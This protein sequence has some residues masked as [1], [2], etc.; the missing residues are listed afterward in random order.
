MKI[1]KLGIVNSFLLVIV[2]VGLV[3]AA[4]VSTV[5][6]AEFNWKV[7]ST[8]TRGDPS[9]EALAYFAE[10]VLKRSNGRIKLEIFAEP[11]LLPL[12]EVLP[13]ASRGAIDI[14]HGGGAIWSMV[15]PSGDVIFGSVPGIWTFPGVS[16]KEGH[17]R[18]RKYL[19]ESGAVD[20]IRKEYAKHNLYW[21]DMHGIGSACQLSTKEVHSLKDIKGMKL[22]DLGGWMAQW[23]SA[24]GWIPVEMMGGAEMM[25]ALKLGTIDAVEYDLSAITSMG[26]NKAAP[27]W[28]SN[29]GF[30]THAVQDMLVN[31]DSWNS[32]SDDLKEAVAAAAED[33][34]HKSS[35]VYTEVQAQVKAMVK[36]GEVIEIL[37]DKEYERVAMEEGMKLWDKASA[38]DPVSAELIRLIKIFRKSMK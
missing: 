21:L 25:M 38:E 9:M 16:V 26:L 5:S 14:A 3:I 36:S 37:M 6:A 13:A 32:L 17:A 2:F 33:Y 28:I 7:H 35:E 30:M 15:V 22:A 18:Q 31:M 34:F 8:W 29:E 12:T 20:L 24:L 23:H 27:Y 4:G 11:E 1:R 19:Y 10:R